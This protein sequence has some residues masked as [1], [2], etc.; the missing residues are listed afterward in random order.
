MSE[1][2]DATLELVLGTGWRIFPSRNKLPAIRNWPNECSRDPAVITRW[3][4]Q[5]PDALPSLVTGPR[6]GIVVLDIDVDREKGYNGWESIETVFKWD[7]AP[8]TPHVITRRGGSHFYYSYP[9]LPDTDILND[10]HPAHRY[11]IKNSVSKLAPHVDVRGWNGHVVLPVAGS[12]YTIDPGLPLG[13]AMLPA[14]AW[15]NHRERKT[16]KPSMTA[17]DGERMLNEACRQ[18]VS[19]V[20][21]TRWD[22]FRHITFTVARHVAQGRIERDKAYHA[23]KGSVIALA[24][25]ADGHYG[26]RV[27]KYFHDAWQEGLAAG[28][29]RR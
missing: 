16:F 20:E 28:E 11:A 9:K 29:R 27:D 5:W 12:G 23:L 2:L 25:V 10:Q 17:F 8:P 19:A 18:I 3:F 1:T 13:M 7:T 15:F 22:A 26:P 21:G 24:V 14:P 6:N 4:R